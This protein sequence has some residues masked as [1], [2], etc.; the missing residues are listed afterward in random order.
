[1]IV[2]DAS[3]W[4]ASFVAQDAHHEQSARLLRRMVAQG[5]QVIAP[6]LA[7]VEVAGALVRR[8]GNPTLAK[9]ALDYL[10]KQSWLNWAPLSAAAS[11]TAAH[12]AITCSLR[13]ADAVYV[14]L[15][16]DESAPLI[17]LDDEMLKRAATVAVAITPGEWLRQNPA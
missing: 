9:T 5:I 15:A 8:T 11:D 12:L 17:T 10:Q 4:V 1:M 14:A 16:R 2:A 13:G 6:T 3:F 7:R